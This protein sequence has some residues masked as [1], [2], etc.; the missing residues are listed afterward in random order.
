[1]EKTKKVEKE[2]AS[3][4]DRLGIKRM[5]DMDRS[6]FLSWVNELGL[7]SQGLEGVVHA[8]L[9]YYNQ[10]QN[11][12]VLVVPSLSMFSEWTSTG[13]TFVKLDSQVQES[14]IKKVPS[15]RLQ[16][17]EPVI[18]L[19]IPHYMRIEGDWATTSVGTEVMFASEAEAAFREYAEKCCGILGKQFAEILAN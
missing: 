12:V 15:Y 16:L 3:E 5:I 8:K 4:W 19:P 9:F 18:S 1:M 10:Y 13:G 7:S 14:L 2:I 11:G 6:T 17:S